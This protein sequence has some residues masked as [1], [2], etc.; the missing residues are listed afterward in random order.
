MLCGLGRAWIALAVIFPAFAPTAS[1]AE[2]RPQVERDLL[3]G[4]SLSTL[5]VSVDGFDS[6]DCS[7]SQR[8]ATLLYAVEVIAASA[9]SANVEVSIII[10]PGRYNSS[11]CGANLTRPLTIV[12][13]GSTNTIVNCGLLHP[14]LSTSSSISISSLTIEEGFSTENGGAV[15]VQYSGSDAAALG[16]AAGSLLAGFTDIVFRNCTCGGN[17]G[18]IAIEAVND[19]GTVVSFRGV[20]LVDNSAGLSGLCVV[21]LKT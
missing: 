5:H 11:S 9:S 17:G 12:G 1:H 10:G 8:C 20:Q 14:L 15:S 7:S 18:A 13:A 3:S 2:S 16:E 6:G 19:T 4:G 21:F